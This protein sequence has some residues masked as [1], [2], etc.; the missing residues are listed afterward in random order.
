M[1]QAVFTLIE[2]LVVIA[3]IA[4]LAAILLPALSKAKL[5]AT[6]VSCL[7]NLKQLTLGAHIYA[8]DNADYIIPNQPST[9]N[10]A[11]TWAFG[12]VSIG[13]GVTNTANI[14]NSLLYQYDGSVANYSCPADKVDVAGIGMPRCAV[15]R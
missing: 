5:R 11:L 12:V 1:A 14:K 9:T 7:N 13:D 6:G 15:T 2:L 8:N 4:I 3:I 10:P